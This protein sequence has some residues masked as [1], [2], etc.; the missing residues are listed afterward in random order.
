MSLFL[1]PF[2]VLATYLFSSTTR[3]EARVFPPPPETVI[4]VKP[5]FTGTATGLQVYAH[6]RPVNGQKVATELPL[7]L[8]A[9]LPTPSI[10][11]LPL[12]LDDTAR[13]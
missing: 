11:P 2:Q 13:G 4:A 9:P 12:P 8:R 7:V 3:D 6:K 10:A 1:R 5:A